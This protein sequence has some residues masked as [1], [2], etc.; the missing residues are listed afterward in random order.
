[1]QNKFS[2]IFLR[3]LI[4]VGIPFLVAP[5][6][7]K[8]L[9]NRLDPKIKKKLHEKYKRFPQFAD[10]SDET[11]ESIDIRG[12]AG[13]ELFW[14]WLTEIVIVDFGPKAIIASTIGSSIWSQTADEAAGVIIKYAATIVAAPGNKFK[15]LYKKLR[16][17]DPK[18]TQEIQ[19][20]LLDKNLSEK[21]KLE[22]VMIKV[23]Q[24]V[25]TLKG[26]KRKKFIAFVMALL[27]FFFGGRLGNSF[28]GFSAVMDAL[29]RL[30]G[31]G[32]IDGDLQSAIIEV[33]QEYN[34]PLPEEFINIIDNIA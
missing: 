19:E 10:I 31:S 26:P 9:L 18:H 21:D 16:K 2:K 5:K 29:R 25:K 22:L 14:L 30:L 15:N 17:I 27:F 20:I 3:Y 12:G 7:E 32:D 28:V 11:T 4:F 13:A 34:A 33:Y 6:I 1:M 23:E 8:F 24:T